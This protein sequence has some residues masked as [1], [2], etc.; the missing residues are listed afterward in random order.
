[1]KGNA[2]VIEAL[3][4]LLVDEFAAWQQYLAHYQA[5]DNLGYA[6]LSSRIK[7]RAADEIRHAEILTA[8]ILVLGGIP[9]A[10]N[11]GPVAVNVSSISA[12]VDLDVAAEIRAVD[13]YN[14]AVKLAADAGDNTTRAILE[15]IL[16][17]EDDEHL[18]EL[19]GWQIEIASLG[20]SP[21][22]ILRGS[23]KG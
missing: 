14:A 18:Y 6:G 7:D 21:F 12:A 16:S 8:R 23:E 11:L 20:L 19:E 13:K 3:N 10:G 17:E 15:T 4:G 2:A 22:L 9:S 5:A 1:M